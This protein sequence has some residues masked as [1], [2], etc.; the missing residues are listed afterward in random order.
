[1]K[2]KKKQNQNEMKPKQNK[3]K[4]K[5]RQVNMPVVR[6]VWNVRHVVRLFYRGRT[7]NWFG[8][9]QKS[10]KSKIEARGPKNSINMHER[11]CLDPKHKTKVW[12]MSLY[13]KKIF[14]QGKIL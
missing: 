3:T 10:S 7:H 11:G 4:V 14:V 9:Q 5:H 8:H 13:G 6:N 2:P 12:E 1:M